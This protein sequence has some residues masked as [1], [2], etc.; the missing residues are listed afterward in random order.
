[1]PT[2]NGTGILD[3]GEK[4]MNTSRGFYGTRKWLMRLGNIIAILGVISVVLTFVLSFVNLPGY[5]YWSQSVILW[6]LIFVASGFT[7]SFYIGTWLLIETD[8]LKGKLSNIML[9]YGT[10]LLFLS[11]GTLF[12]LGQLFDDKWVL[13][14]YRLYVV[15][16]AIFII[17]AYVIRNQRSHTR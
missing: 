1:M 14:G 5:W 3:E 7:L 13:A 17:R 16:I 6:S 11:G 12:I 2:Q 4:S 8:T 9:N 15:G 10:G